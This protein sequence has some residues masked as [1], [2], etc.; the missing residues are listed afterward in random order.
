MNHMIT[1]DSMIQSSDSQKRLYDGQGLYLAV[2]RRGGARGWRLDYTFKGRRKTISL[3]GYPAVSL[4]AARKSAKEY[5]ELLAQDIDPSADRKAMRKNAKAGN[6]CFESVAQRWL[7]V[8]SKRRSAATQAKI[9]KRLQN[10]IFPTLGKRKT[11]TIDS[12]MLLA[13]LR[14]VEGRGAV[15]TAHRLLGDLIAIF[16]FAVAEGLVKLNPAATLR[17]AL[18]PSVPSNYAAIT[19]PALLSPLLLAM[20]GYEG[21]VVVRCALRLLPMLAVRP[22]QLRRAEWQ[23]IDFENGCWRMPAALRKGS[24]H[25][26]R[27]GAGHWTPLPRQAIEILKELHAFTGESRYLFP[28]ERSKERPMSENTINAA[29]R[30]L[31]Y[32]KDDM[33]GHGFRATLQT[34]AENELFVDKNLIEVQLQHKVPGP[35]A[36]IYNRADYREFRRAT[37]QTWAD[38]LDA[39]RQGRGKEFTDRIRRA[40]G[41]DRIEIHNHRVLCDLTATRSDAGTDRTPP[42]G[43]AVPQRTR[44]PFAGSTRNFSWNAQ[45]WTAMPYQMSA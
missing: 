12:S 43:A 24:R 30:N 41:Y 38:Y 25:V 15:E 18:E 45:G 14:V 10:D 44:Q 21:T 37:M 31:G 6:E 2:G 26:K 36:D 23:H 27:N 7:K 40:F 35:L 4:E 39:L 13:A 34:I 29:L 19:D 8:R 1:D 20:D 32:S 17:D 3:G 42:P 22:G 9:L 5:R 28:G 33:T 11:V 16:N